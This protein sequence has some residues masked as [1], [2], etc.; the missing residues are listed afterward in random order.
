MF[1]FCYLH[2]QN[3][4]SMFYLEINSFRNYVLHRCFILQDFCLLMS[5]KT[6]EM[7]PETHFKDT[8]RVFSK[9]DEG[10]FLVLKF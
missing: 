8:F 7:D 5:E 4:A 9:D 10:R 6:K 3:T 1:I 2:E